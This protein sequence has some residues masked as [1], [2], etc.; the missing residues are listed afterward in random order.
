MTSSSERAEYSSRVG[1]SLRARRPIWWLL[2]NVVQWTLGVTA[3][4]GL[5][6][7]AALW[8]VGLAQIPAPATPTLGILPVPL[9]MLVG[10]VLLGLLLGVVSRWW[11]RIGARRRTAA[12]GKRLTG[13]VAKVADE[14]IVIPVDE[15]LDRHR[16][17]REHLDRAAG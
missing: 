9:V 6:W 10:G 3:A 4:L 14:R 12:I 1:T 7:L 16:E 2:V 8:V 11:A 15:V 5:L 13:A 17:T